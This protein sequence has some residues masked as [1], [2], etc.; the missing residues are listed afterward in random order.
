M[1]KKRGKKYIEAAK[2]VE[3]AVSS[4][5]NGGLEPE[6]AV[7]LVRETS[8][9]KFDATIEAHI[10]LGVDPR[11][12]EQ[13]VRGS[14]V[15]PNG[16]G[17]KV[18]V[19]VFAVRDKAREAQEAGADIVGGD[20]LVKRVSDGWTDFDAAIATPDMMATVGPLGKILG[21]RGM[22]H[23]PKSATVPNDVAVT[24]RHS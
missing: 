21:P 19:A 9:S 16:T 17:K 23:N 8:I 10:R 22:M 20:D 14:V 13:M 5:G 7:Q 24:R 4:N 15:L 11:H 18:R 6:V 2:K 3:A 1:P 12:A